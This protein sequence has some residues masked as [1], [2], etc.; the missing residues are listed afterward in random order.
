MP[1][2][3]PDNDYWRWA[4]EMDLVSSDHYLEAAD[5]MSHVGL[6]MDADLTRSLGQGRP[7]LLM[8]HS[9]SAVSWQ[10]HNIAKDPGQERRN[11]LAHVARGADGVLAFQWRASRR[12]AEK[13]HSAML[14]FAG[15]D[16]RVFREVCSLGQDLARLAPTVG[17]RVQA[18][19][20]LVWDWESF[21]A[22]D[23]PWRP[24]VLMRHRDQVRAVYQWLWERGTTTDLVHPE[25]DLS[26]YDVVIAPAAYLLSP[27]GGANLSDFVERG[28]RLAVL[29]FSGVVDLSE[30]LLHTPEP[31]RQQL[32]FGGGQ[33]PIDMVVSDRTAVDHPLQRGAAGDQPVANALAQFGSRA[34]AEGHRQDLPQRDAL[35]D[36]PGDHAGDG[37]RLAGAG[38]GL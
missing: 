22:Q 13:F 29:P 24:S 25:A 26:A 32:R 37:V 21:W 12:G 18:S 15:E 36:E 34:T 7:W 6:A 4:P 16:T 20:A 19:V 17:S 11:A 35:A 27:A 28:G 38:A 14:P 1:T 8:E 33:H 2:N 5:P 31:G 10:P 3:C 30:G 9:T 23:L